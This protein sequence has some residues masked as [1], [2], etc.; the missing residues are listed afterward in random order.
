M[1]I[2]KQYFSIQPLIACGNYYPP[3]RPYSM[4]P[5][6]DGDSVMTL[7]G[8]TNEYILQYL[9]D[10]AGVREVLPEPFKPTADPIVT[11]I[12]EYNND[13]D[14]V[15]GGT[16]HLSTILLRCKLDGY[17]EGNYC[18]M[19]PENNNFCMLMGRDASGVPKMFANLPR[20]YV[21][22][23]G[24]H[25]TCEARSLSYVNGAQWEPW[26]GVNFGPMEE[27]SEEEAKKW[28]KII[29]D[30]DIYATKII[31]GN[32]AEPDNGFEIFSS[33]KYKFFKD[34]KK[35]WVGKEADFYWNENLEP[36]LTM[37]R[38]TVDAFKKYLP[39]K[40]VLHTIHWWGVVTDN[41]LDK[42]QAYIKHTWD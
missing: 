40:E 15:E 37:E 26:Y 35:C 33:I 20:P 1:K 41:P 14:V 38:R 23:D 21:S 25:T 17:G 11:V 24:T 34:I 3:L 16:Y 12:F 36:S 30:H 10:P 39:V 2:N 32:G 8:S 4:R 19:M 13:S 28:A 18:L 5:R 7:G 9:T 6:Y 42:D 31:P 27:V 29:S 22:D